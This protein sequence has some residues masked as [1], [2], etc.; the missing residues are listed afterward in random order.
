MLRKPITNKIIGQRTNQIFISKLLRNP[1][2]LYKNSPDPSISVHA[3]CTR[4]YNNKSVQLPYDFY[5]HHLGRMTY[6]ELLH[7]TRLDCGCERTGTGQTKHYSTQ[8][9]VQTKINFKINKRVVGTVK[10]D[11]LYLCRKLKY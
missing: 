5:T 11:N 3:L 4:V 7:L 2:M 10:N 9:C 6:I 8:V 1:N